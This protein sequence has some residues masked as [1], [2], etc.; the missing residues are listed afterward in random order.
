MSGGRAGH[1]V[2]YQ[3]QSSMAECGAA[4][5]AMVLTAFGHGVSVRETRQQLRVGRDGS[6]ALGLARAAR[7]A[8]LTVRGVRCTG[9]ELVNVPMPVIAH[10]RHDHFVVVDR[11]GR[12]SVSVV[13]PAHGR[14]RIPLSEFA[15][16]FGGVVLTFSGAARP[17]RSGTRGLVR[18]LL[19]QAP[20]RPGAIVTAA[21]ASLLATA[22]GLLP[23]F[24]VGLTVDTLVP[25]G[26]SDL[27]GLALLALGAV[28]MSRVLV[29]ILRAGVLVR[30]Q[31]AV[32][33]SL[34]TRVVHHLFR[35]PMRFYDL[36]TVGDLLNRVRSNAVIRQVLT[37]QVLVGF[38]DLVTALVYLGLLLVVAPGL[39][40]VVL[41]VVL[42][43]L[44]LLLA[45]TGPLH[46]M[47]RREIE[48]GAQQQSL[49]LEALAGIESVKMSALEEPILARWSRTFSEEVRAA[50]R[51]QLW[52]SRLD[53][54]TDVVQ[55][56]LGA[57]IVLA[58][59]YAVIQGGASLG[60]MLTGAYIASGLLVPLAGL[61]KQVRSLHVV[62]VHLARLRD[63]L[64]EEA[65][66]RRG[67]GPTRPDTGVPIG[68]VELR[69][70]SFSYG[71]SGAGVR[72]ASLRVPAGSFVAITGASG[73]GKSTLARM[74]L[75]VYRPDSGTAL[76]GGREA[77]ALSEPEFVGRC[78]AV[79]QEPAVFSGT[80]ADNLRL[81][82]RD[83][84][85]EDIG[86]A[87]RLAELHRDVEAMPMGYRTH[88]SER[89]G[90]LSGGQRQRLALA[91]AL[92]REPALLVLD[93]ATSS[94]DPDT[95]L[96]IL[97][98]LRALGATVVLVAHR[99]STILHADRVV[100]MDGGRIVEQGTH[101]EL[102]AMGGLYAA[103]LHR[104]L[105]RSFPNGSSA[106]YA[107][108]S[109]GTA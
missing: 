60:S 83:A 12:R 33:E 57:G 79:A 25:R 36:R 23:A 88:L 40:V 43:Q 47:A 103:T 46:A 16:E 107:R 104:Q 53:D 101:D 77:W 31:V 75:G 14:S 89:G 21:L 87:A 58:G 106:A 95:E 68:E 65:A 108:S 8:G 17:R 97:G 91:R 24:A 30:L 11:V 62:S 38:L 56:A 93:E 80:I 27:V 66:P 78:A 85:D 15:E 7:D 99:L 5:L 86:R 13:D 105:A 9:P 81:G 90:G 2:R 49:V 94:V 100:V 70:A 34:T 48:L 73:S 51:R 45:G 71:A 74:L 67:E 82:R 76:V 29:G 59:S 109:P 102:L 6:T 42:V 35:L 3:A 39:A 1:R 72:S 54:L 22:A 92:I 55:V 96:A 98:N 61:V 4:C 10:L 32:D 18:F 63:L 84:T 41:A 64:D 52:E 50:G 19:D 28:V 20:R 37:T 26:S 69:Q 44:A